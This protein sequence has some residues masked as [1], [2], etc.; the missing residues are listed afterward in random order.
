M[1][2]VKF[3]K[4]IRIFLNIKKK[5]AYLSFPSLYFSVLS[6][7]NETERLCFAAILVRYWAAWRA[8]AAISVG[9]SQGLSPKKGL[10]S[11]N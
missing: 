9:C 7:T 11:V 8:N 4:R 1:N 3:P 10:C 2:I 5:P 6:T